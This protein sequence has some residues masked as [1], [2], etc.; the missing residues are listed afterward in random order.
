MSVH[1]RHNNVVHYLQH[2]FIVLSFPHR[3]R[4]TTAPYQHSVTTDG[5]FFNHFIVSAS[6]VLF[7]RANRQLQITI[8]GVRAWRDTLAQ[9]TDR[10]LKKHKLAT[11]VLLL[12]FSNFLL[13]T[14]FGQT[15]ILLTNNRQVSKWFPRYPTFYFHDSHDKNKL[16]YVCI[17]L[18]IPAR[19]CNLC[20]FN[21]LQQ[22]NTSVN[23][24]LG[25][26]R[27]ELTMMPWGSIGEW[28]SVNL[29]TWSRWVVSFTIGFMF[30][31]LGRSLSG[32]TAST[33]EGRT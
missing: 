19:S 33:E 16:G 4:L 2:C 13:D 1:I 12:L 29:G 3:A 17:T 26:K 14:R 10:C 28:R 15:M 25:I 24:A 30:A 23:T 27:A 8:K 32:P 6:Y 5:V 31:V 11:W 7:C 20:V 22:C 21:Y 9:E 18:T